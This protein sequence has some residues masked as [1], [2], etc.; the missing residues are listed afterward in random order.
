MSNFFLKSICI[1]SLAFTQLSS[2]K[3]EDE[4]D[5]T[6][7]IGDT[8]K[9]TISITSPSSMQVYYNGDTV[10]ISG[11]VSDASLHELLIK[12]L[13]D[14][15]NSVLFSE[16]PT[17]HDLSTYTIKTNWKSQVSDHTNAR[18]IVVAKDHSL[19]V[20]SDTVHIH[21]MP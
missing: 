4:H 10:K 14:S 2:C 6:H 3:K 7:E 13:K 17:V 15:D 8:A 5:Q 19:N 1:L 21:I 16:T 12:I 9:P 18:L 20:G 11:L